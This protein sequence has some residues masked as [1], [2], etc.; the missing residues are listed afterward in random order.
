MN[1]LIKEAGFE[2]QLE[3]DHEPKIVVGYVKT[4]VPHPDSDHLSITETEVDN[5]TVLQGFMDQII[6]NE[7]I[8]SIVA[9]P[10]VD[11]PK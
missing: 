7:S 8:E 6:E 2:E 5:G 4:C 11:L 10:G 3:A 9:K 1:R